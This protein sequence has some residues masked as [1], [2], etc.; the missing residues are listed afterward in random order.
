MRVME[1][2]GMAAEVPP[3]KYAHGKHPDSEAARA[4]GMTEN[5]ERDHRLHSGAGSI[6]QSAYLLGG[7]HLRPLL[8]PVDSHHLPGWPLER[9]RP[10]LGRAREEP[11]VVGRLVSLER[12]VRHDGS[13]IIVDGHGVRF[14]DKGVTM[15][16]TALT[17]AGC[18]AAKEIRVSNRRVGSVGDEHKRL[19]FQR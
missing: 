3:E 7:E 5:Q 15:L 17:A 2:P 6:N 13:G 12:L 10:A 9:L 16:G 18:A 8:G 19:V 4:K 1:P 14:L 11:K